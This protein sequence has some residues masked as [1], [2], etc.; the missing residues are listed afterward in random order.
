MT[1][2]PDTWERLARALEYPRDAPLP[3]QEQYAEAFDFDPSC[4]LDV[5]WHLFG[6]AVERGTLLAR[7][8]DDL[9]RAGVPENGELPDHLATLLRLLARE[10]E[11]SARRHAALMIPAV[12]R[13]A[14]RL[15]ERGSP[16]SDI[17][18]ETVRMLDMLERPE[19]LL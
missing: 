17:L 13:V 11:P 16:F 19:A 8:R 15:R 4:S 14:E 5:G 1:P 2:S 6:D 3:I 12:A 10:D 9:A 18:D 7:L